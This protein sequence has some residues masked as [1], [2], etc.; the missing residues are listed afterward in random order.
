MGRASPTTQVEE[1]LPGEIEA[2]TEMAT[3]L[4]DARSHRDV[5]AAIMIVTVPTMTSST[6]DRMATPGAELPAAT[7]L[8][9][10]VVQVNKS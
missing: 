10:G 2:A 6:A 1:A 4:I 9:A 7:V 8:P 5:A 3:T